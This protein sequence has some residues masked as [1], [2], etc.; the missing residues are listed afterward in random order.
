MKRN[1]ALIAAAA[2]AALVGTGI[3]AYFVGMNRGWN[4]A[5]APAATSA[6]PADPSAWT[7]PQGEAATKRHIKDG[8]K[9]GDMDPATGREVLYY[10]DPMVPGKRF[11]APAKSPFMDM[12]LVPCTPALAVPTP[13]R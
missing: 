9:A 13:A 5:A 4:M 3:G 6:A 2:L 7:I 10:H 11:D 8:V 12:M 1:T